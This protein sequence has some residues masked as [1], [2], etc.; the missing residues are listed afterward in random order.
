[1]AEFGYEDDLS[2]YRLALVTLK[3]VDHDDEYK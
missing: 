1:M 3:G 2:T